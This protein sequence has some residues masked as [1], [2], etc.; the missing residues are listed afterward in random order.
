MNLIN[1]ILV[2]LII[3]VSV[4]LQKYT[5]FTNTASR[6]YA[7]QAAKAI[8]E[9]RE[10]ITRQIIF[11]DNTNN[12]VQSQKIKIN[13]DVWFNASFTNAQSIVIQRN[14]SNFLMVQYPVVTKEPS[15]DHVN[16]LWKCITFPSTDAFVACRNGFLND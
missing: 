6:T 7:T 1:T 4:F 10:K 5:Q 11:N 12:L 2:I 14:D 9:H 13:S 8:E 15:T 16:V 3:C